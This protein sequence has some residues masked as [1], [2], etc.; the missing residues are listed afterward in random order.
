MTSISGPTI[1]SI[2]DIFKGPYYHP[3]VPDIH[4]NLISALNIQNWFQISHL[5]KTEHSELN[6]GHLN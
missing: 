4:A 3:I 2:M 6:F 5:P 1:Q